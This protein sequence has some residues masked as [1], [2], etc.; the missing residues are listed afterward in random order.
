M[1]FSMKLSDFWNGRQTVTGVISHKLICRPDYC[2][3]QTFFDGHLVAYEKTIDGKREEYE[4]YPLPFQPKSAKPG[5]K[6]AIVAGAALTAAG[7]GFAI[8]RAVR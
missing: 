7:V 5:R 1:S 6:I 2:I 4:E 8:Y 3:K